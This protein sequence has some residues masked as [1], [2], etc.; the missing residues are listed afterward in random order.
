MG[1]KKKIFISPLDWGLGHA[2]RCIP[3]IQELK[4]QG[5]EVF[6]GADRATYDLL[7]KEFP[8]T[9]FIKFPGYDI[10]YSKRGN[11]LWQMAKLSP[12]IIGRI[13]IEK[14]YLQEIINTHHIDGVISDNRFGLYND[15]IP[16]V[17]I[18][19]QLFIKSTFGNGVIKKINNFFIR[20]HNECWVPDFENEAL[21][22]SGELSH[23]S[24]TSSNIHFIGPLS[25]FKN[26]KAETTSEFDLL[27]II[28]GPEPQ[29]T[30]FEKKV[31]DQL[32]DTNLKTLIVQG[33]PGQKH[34]SKINSITIV[35]HLDTS[36]MEKAI[37]SSNIVLSRSGY[38]TVMDLATIGK[39]AIFIPTPGQTEQ[40][41]LAKHHAAAGNC[42][43]DKQKHFNVNQL[44]SD[45]NT[46]KGFQPIEKI[47][48]ISAHVTRFLEL[49]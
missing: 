33:K 42:V 7:I 10:T 13:R 47:N 41:Y 48:N 5:A 39:K 21:S 8:T 44:I 32:K 45:A 6:I 15:D 29:R 34:S 23:K 11:M 36:K 14:K 4:R 38:T 18:T 31:I 9:A 37:N 35:N 1:S 40:K 25:R 49:I 46:I 2:T 17:F 22:L 26:K 3:I 12:K 30:I 28:S 43:W 19:H 16:T 27:A 20:Q 24:K